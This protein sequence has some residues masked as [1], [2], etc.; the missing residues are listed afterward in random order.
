MRLPVDQ[1]YQEREA[2]ASGYCHLSCLHARMLTTRPLPALKASPS[3]TNAQRY[4]LARASAWKSDCGMGATQTS[5]LA[6]RSLCSVS[7]G[8]EGAVELCSML[9]GHQTL[10]SRRL[11][12]GRVQRSSA[13]AFL[14][15]KRCGKRA[16]AKFEGEDINCTALLLLITRLSLGVVGPFVKEANVGHVVAILPEILCNHTQTIGRE[17][18]TT[19]IQLRT[20]HLRIRHP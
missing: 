6:S 3:L 14:V 15:S 11:Q 7:A 17:R 1:L 4:Q 16:S 13:C 19:S 5:S 12:T 18:V 20:T 8:G 10:A 9:S 2:L